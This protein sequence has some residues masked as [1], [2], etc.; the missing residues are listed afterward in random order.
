MEFSQL[1]SGLLLFHRNLVEKA[2]TSTDDE[3]KELYKQAA[4]YLWEV[5]KN[6]EEFDK[7]M[8]EIK[9]RESSSISPN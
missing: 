9:K 8:K 4:K 2:Q 1:R 6:L 3:L 5:I 7:T